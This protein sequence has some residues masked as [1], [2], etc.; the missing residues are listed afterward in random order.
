MSWSL[1]LAL[2]LAT[3]ACRMDLGEVD[4]VFY[5]GDGRLVHCAVAIDRAAG[6]T[7]ASIDSALD[8]A[9]D[10][11]EVVELYAHRPALSLSL[12]TI[13]HVLAGARDRGLAFVTYADFAAG[14]GT[15]PGVALSF[16]DSD[17]PSWMAAR[18]LFARYE[19]RVTFFVTRY[20]SLSE[21][22]RGSIRALAN[23]GHD[24]EAHSVLHLRAPSYVEDHGLRAYLDDEAVPS[25]DV[26]R[27]A[28]YPVTAYAYP[29][30]ARTDE[31]DRALGKHVT[32]V[33]SVSYAEDGVSDPCP[34]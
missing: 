28:G 7:L 33:R 17:V 21:R 13:E 25:I 29:F 24:I 3:T 2:G 9:A 1:A 27:A 11:H 10:R 32:I 30:G 14:G 18:S 5:D 23:D 8:R 16:D 22:D 19:A 15:G 12:A 6:N 34:R 20:G 26:L 4:G 31:L